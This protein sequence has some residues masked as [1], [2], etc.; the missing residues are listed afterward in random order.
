VRELRGA[1]AARISDR[2][3][4][5]PLD[6]QPRRRA[7][8]RRGRRVLPLGVAH[9]QD[10]RRGLTLQ[11]H[12]RARDNRGCYQGD[13][14]QVQQNLRSADTSHAHKSSELFVKACAKMPLLIP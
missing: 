5:A 2:R 6:A 8:A 12:D 7:L 10:R 1:L 14:D 13:N 11:V 4:L 9:E 3:A